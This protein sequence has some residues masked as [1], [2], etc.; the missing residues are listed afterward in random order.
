[1]NWLKQLPTGICQILTIDQDLRSPADFGETNLG[2]NP[3][4]IADVH[5]CP[6]ISMREGKDTNDH[7]ARGEAGALM[8]TAR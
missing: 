1:M 3:L 6:R 4:I 7:R 2:W 5:P 8:A